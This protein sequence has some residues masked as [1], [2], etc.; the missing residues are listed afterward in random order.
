MFPFYFHV[1]LASFRRQLAYRWANIAGLITNTFFGSLF[2]FVII[3]LHH[4]RQSVDGYTV[5][6]TLRY[7]WLAQALLMVVMPFAWYDLMNTIRTGEVVSDLSKPCDFCWYWFS[8][9][10][11]RSLYYTLFRGVPI[12]IAGTLLFNLGFPAGSLQLLIFVL[13]FLLAIVLGIA[14]RYLYNIIAFWIVEARAMVWLAVTVALFF[15][16][17]YIPLYFLPGWLY[18]LAQVLP[19]NG[20]MNFPIQV[21]LGKVSPAQMGWAFVSLLCWSVGMI[22]VMRF[23]TARA[24]RR[25][26]VQGG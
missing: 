11:G 24:T 20:L 9:E 23:L 16:G 15:A 5:T 7:T 10:L 14:Y 12:Y 2:S 25:V 8:R 22:L 21:L 13:A 17:S 4:A 18:G 6:D 3:A 19:F 26:I 1:A